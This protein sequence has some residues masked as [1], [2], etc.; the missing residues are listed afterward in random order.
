MKAVP[1]FS[2]PTGSTHRSLN[3]ENL[4]GYQSCHQTV[5]NKL[6][7][8]LI[9]HSHD[10]VGWLKTVDQYYFGGM[11]D[12]LFIYVET[13]YF[14]KWWQLQ[15][16]AKQTQVKTLVNEGRLE[17]AGG[18]W[19]AEA[20]LFTSVLYNHY[21][22]PPGFCFDM[23]C[24]DSDIIDDHTSGRYNADEMVSDFVS[25]AKDQADRY[26]SNHILVPM[27]DDFNY[28]EAKRYF[29]N[30][31]RL[32]RNTNEMRQD[33]HV[34]YST[35]SCYLKA[36]NDVG[37]T[38]GTKQDDFFPYASD[39]SSK[40]MR[41]ESGDLNL[42]SCM[43]LN[44]SK[45]EVTENETNFVV[46]VYNPLSRNNSNY[47]RFP[48]VPIPESV[49][50]VPGKGKTDAKLDLVFRAENIPP[51]GYHSYYVSLINNSSIPVTPSGDL[52][53]GSEESIQLTLNNTSGL[54]REVISRGVRIPLEQNFL[55]YPASDF[56]GNS[57]AYVFRPDIIHPDIYPVS[58]LAT[59]V[60]I[61]AIS[62]FTTNLA[63]N[64]VF[65]TDSN[66]RELLKRQRNSRPTWDMT[67]TEKI[68]GNY[69]PVTSR[70]VI[71]DAEQG[72]EVAI[73][74]DR[75]QGGSSINN[76][77]IEL[78]VVRGKHY[79]VVGNAN[80][81]NSGPTMAAVERELAL[82]KLL[83][84]WLFFTKTALNFNQWQSSHKM[85][86][87]ELLLRLE[88]IMEKNEDPELSKPVQ[89]NLQDL[90]NTFTITEIHETNLAGNQWKEDMNRLV[91]K[92]GTERMK[93]S[94]PLHKGPI[95]TLKPMDIL[96]YVIKVQR[97]T[98]IPDY[99]VLRI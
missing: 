32:V 66:G 22:A 70:I 98:I 48:L 49:L 41:N 71:R 18:A 30:L 9:P 27:G 56:G 95:V 99:T 13:A 21:S 10:D 34:L 50:A 82:K 28:Q 40:L 62:V 96:T 45:C 58:D 3:K 92:T 63:T 79:L 38:Y 7:V 53:I 2:Q 36:V 33:V 31:D 51:L 73:L 68:A 77:Q 44:I 88:H 24:D 17:F 26:T 67:L 52:F 69:Y 76:G 54:V 55:Y 4:C 46:T 59:T 8:H 20:D 23:L 61:E 14:W 81:N 16:E 37:E 64:E 65:Y 87:N 91:W 6:N 47:V 80:G 42:R 74:N 35:P 94:K 39:S 90:F 43:Y 60:V 83:Q 5:P 75:S 11:S 29:E 86:E 85:E 19:R 84:P 93:S 57:G 1:C 89:V 12:N 78:M 72:N 15:T 25:Y 97:K